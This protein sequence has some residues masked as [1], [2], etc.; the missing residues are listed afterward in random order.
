MCVI[1]AGLTCAGAGVQ[2]YQ[3]PESHQSDSG[4]VRL[5]RPTTINTHVCGFLPALD[6]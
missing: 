6:I 5:L 2:P 3:A 1:M 4:Q